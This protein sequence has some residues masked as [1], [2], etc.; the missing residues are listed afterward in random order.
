MILLNLMMMMMMMINCR[1][2]AESWSTCSVT[3]GSGIRSR[4]IECVQDVNSQLTVRISDGACTESKSPPVTEICEMPI[5][6]NL[7]NTTELISSS[8]SQWNTGEWSE[9]INQPS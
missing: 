7:F 1:W 5:C 2:R 6:K 8:F 3:C 4:D 9:V